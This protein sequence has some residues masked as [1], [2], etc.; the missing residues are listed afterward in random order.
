MIPIVHRTRESLCIKDLFY[1]TLQVT[2]CVTLHK[3]MTHIVLIRNVYKPVYTKVY[4]NRLNS[5]KVF[6]VQTIWC[7]VNVF[8]QFSSGKP[9]T[10][11]RSL[12]NLWQNNLFEETKNGRLDH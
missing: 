12:E 2:L 10:Y 5:K 6:L 4:S 1:V 7:S 9:V 3:C 8:Y 11:V